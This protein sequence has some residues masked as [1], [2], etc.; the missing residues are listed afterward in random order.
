MQEAVARQ[1]AEIRHVFRA[2]AMEDILRCCVIFAAA[3]ASVLGTFPFGVACFSAFLDM[4]AAYLGWIAVGLAVFSAGGSAGGYVLACVLFWLYAEL[5][6]RDK[7]LLSSMAVCGICVI[8]GGLYDALTSGSAF[9]STVMLGA[10]GLLSGLMFYVFRRAERFMK[11]SREQPAQEEL[12]CGVIAL[13]VLLMGI[14]GLPI[15]LGIDLSMILGIFILLSVSLHTG[16]AAAG[17]FGLAIGFIC[18]MN[19]PAAI[20]LTGVF[21][22]SAVFSNLLRSFGKLGVSL[23]FLLG[24]TISLLY[25]GDISAMPIS[26]LE[27]FLSCLLF[28]ATPRAI[29]QR[30]GGRISAVFEVRDKK[31]DRRVKQ[32]LSGELKSFAK[33]FGDLANN[34]LAEPA[35]QDE[36]YSENVTAFLEEVAGR[37]CSSCKKAGECWGE[38]REETYQQAYMVFEI[39]EREGSC[40]MHNLP[41]VF[42][43][44]CIQ[45]ENFVTVFNHVYELY[46][47]NTLWKGEANI[48]QGLVARQYNEISNI[49]RGLSY[50]VEGG[51]CFLEESEKRIADKLLGEGVFVKDVSV[52]ENA[53][54][55]Y[56]VEIVPGLDDPALGAEIVSAVLGVPMRASVSDES[57]TKFTAASQFQLEIGLRQQTKDG[58]EVSGDTVQYFETAENKFFLVLCDGM[59]SGGEANAQS[60]QTAALLAEF[61]RAGISK[62]TAVNMINSTLALKTG[63]ESFTT[64]DIA[65]IDLR[66]GDAEFLK[67]GAAPGYRKHKQSVETIEAKTLPIGI[68]EEARPAVIRRTL[69]DGDVLVLASDGVSEAGHGAIRGEWIKK[70]MRESHTMDRLAELILE[71]ASSKAY[72]KISDDMTVACIQIQRV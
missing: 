6:L 67:V 12:V 54:G 58:E 52:I 23:G 60:G 7:S 46:K 26:L 68:L 4:E 20:L 16:L 55:A 21:G 53:K 43:Q 47:Q 17:C 15:P 71:N 45:A 40:G 9:Y 31:T 65:E 30:I 3:R 32:Y 13:G 41:I 62:E 18:S 25:I 2:P 61:L 14:S 33:A 38:K 35:H 1:R 10:E 69:G 37:A 44:R 59:G 29:H 36:I 8:A 42:K 63:N 24:V 49:M 19:Q 50:E 22:I 48:G 57:W 39:M 5:K 34:F 56:A 64:V 51:F 28:A 70:T 72:P 11:P 66:T 27:L